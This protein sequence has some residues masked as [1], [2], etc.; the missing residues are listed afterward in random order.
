MT[1]EQVQLARPLG[2]PRG[3]G[4]TVTGWVRLGRLPSYAR[5][6][7]PPAIAA[8]KSSATTPSATAAAAAATASTGWWSGLAAA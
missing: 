7:G 6:I 8:A 3:S 2:V 4:F 5:Y 1:V